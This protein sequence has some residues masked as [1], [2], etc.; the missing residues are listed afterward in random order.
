MSTQ[1]NAGNL[2]EFS[3]HLADLKHAG[4]FDSHVEILAY[5]IKERQLESIENEL[6]TSCMLERNRQI[7][8]LAHEIFERD[9]ILNKS[10][11]E[12][13]AQSLSFNSILGISVALSRTYALNPEFINSMNYGLRLFLDRYTD[14][15]TEEY[16]KFSYDMENIAMVIA[17]MY[18]DEDQGLRVFNAFS[19]QY[20]RYPDVALSRAFFNIQHVGVKVKI[21]EGHEKAS[22]MADQWLRAEFMIHQGLLQQPL[23]AP[24]LYSHF[25]EL[26]TTQKNIASEGFTP[27]KHELSPRLADI[28]AR[29]SSR[30]EQMVDTLHEHLKNKNT[31][32]ALMPFG[33]RTTAKGWASLMQNMKIFSRELLTL[34]LPEEKRTAV[35]NECLIKLMNGKN[36]P[37]LESELKHIVNDLETMVNW[38]VVMPRLNENSSSLLIKLARDT[39]PFIDLSNRQQRGFILSK[40][41]GI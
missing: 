34:D 14:E 29:I 4:S 28:S 9:D 17:A 27:L 35:A 15:V 41:M 24:L 10:D 31:T 33:K 37:E 22:Q 18:P 13:F 40:D 11:Y 38:A 2:R 8:C 19:S 25:I 23:S 5:C 16:Y 30:L 6:K 12:F 26:V 20:C 39:S 36:R 7:L 21:M 3:R 32:T 1:D